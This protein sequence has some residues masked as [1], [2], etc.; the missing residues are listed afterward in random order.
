MKEF[1]DELQEA[2]NRD[3]SRPKPWVQA[4][5]FFLNFILTY[6]TIILVDVYVTEFQSSWSL[7]LVAIGVH[8]VLDG[9]WDGVGWFRQRRKFRRE[10]DM[11]SD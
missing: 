6:A 1:D 4:V 3:I 2:L 9:L 8:I 5:K 7:L 10:N 11:V